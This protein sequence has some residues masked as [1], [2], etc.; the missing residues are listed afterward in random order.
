MFLQKEHSVPSFPSSA[1]YLDESQEAW[2]HNRYGIQPPWSKV[3]FRN[4]FAEQRIFP[5]PKLLIR[6]KA[7]AENWK[8]LRFAS[9]PCT[10]QMPVSALKDI[11]NT[12]C[13]V[14]NALL[15][16]T[17]T[18]Q[19]FPRSGKHTPA[20]YSVGAFPDTYLKVLPHPCFLRG[21][22]LLTSTYKSGN[23]HHHAGTC[24]RWVAAWTE[25]ATP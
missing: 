8:S 5:L 1:Q 12:Y 13:R 4:V 19:E 23:Q 7:T 22:C 20:R 14:Y 10:A 11:V 25:G 21:K 9:L 3:K 18:R 24:L 16:L 2:W 15:F 6:I 17:V